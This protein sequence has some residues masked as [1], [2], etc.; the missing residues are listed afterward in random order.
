MSIAI[1]KVIII[2]PCTQHLMKFARP[3]GL[4]GNLKYHDLYDSADKNLV[5]LPEDI[6]IFKQKSCIDS[7]NI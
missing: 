7:L 2:T 3:E 6:S 5:V 4:S 1:Q